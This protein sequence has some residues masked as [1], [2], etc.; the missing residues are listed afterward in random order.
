MAWTGLSSAWLATLLL[1]HLTQY[2]LPPALR[3][4]FRKH[5]WQPWLLQVALISSL[6]L[7]W[8]LITRRPLLAGLLTLAVLT[9]LLVVN[10]A[11]C[12]ALQEPL[13]FSDIHLYLQVIRHPRL[14]L[15][16][17][18]LPLTV[19]AILVGISLLL[20]AIRME[21]AS[22]LT[23]RLGIPGFYAL[24]SLLGLACIGLCGQLARRLTLEWEPATDIR[25]QGFYN[26]LLAYTLQARTPTAQQQFRDTI[27]HASPFA[28]PQS[29]TTANQHAVS[30]S[31]QP[32][33]IVI[34]SESFCDARR[35]SPNI[36]TDLLQ[37]FDQ[38][39]ST[40][41]AQGRLQVPAWGANTLRPEFAFLSGIRNARLG[42]YRF[43]PYQ[44]LRTFASIPTLASHLQQRGYRCIALHPHHASFFGR[45]QV[46]PRCGFEDFI[47]IAGFDASSKAG[48]YISD[49]AVQQKIDELLS[50]PR[51]NDHYSCS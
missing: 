41:P 37:H 11:K 4:A 7:G 12:H 45:D 38:L 1:A 20:I 50:Q 33:L 30:A 24:S 27:R 31:Q 6:Y 23:N 51:T 21:P 9:V 15:P 8:L 17:L 42:P 13:V 10:H 35:F 36:R 2:L 22:I 43:N 49:Q 47:D 39:R 16:F 25:R 29:Q 19:T 48:P 5:D 40:A 46:Y 3:P 14:F 32:D 44:Y 34:Q 28:P 18:N 26:S